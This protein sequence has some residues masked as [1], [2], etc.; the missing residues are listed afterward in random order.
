MGSD[1][2]ARAKT[3][4][5]HNERSDRCIYRGETLRR[6][7]KSCCGT[8]EIFECAEREHEVWNTKCRS[9]EF[10]DPGMPK[11]SLC[12]NT[13]N[14]GADLLQTILSFRAAY[15]GPFECIVIADGTTDDSIEILEQALPDIDTA[16]DCCPRCGNKDLA[17]CSKDDDEGP[18]YEAAKREGHGTAWTQVVLCEN[19]D[20]EASWN[21]RDSIKIIRNK[22]R[23]GCG[24][25]KAQAL[26]AA[27]GDV[28]MYSDGH[29]R[30]FK[31]AIDPL[32]ELALEE[33]C[34][35]CPGGAP[36]HC[37]AHEQPIFKVTDAQGKAITKERKRVYRAAVKNGDTRIGGT[38]L[39]YV[40][41]LN[42]SLPEKMKP[43]KI[44][45]GG[46]IRV[47]EHGLGI[48][49]AGKPHKDYGL[50]NATWWAVFLASKHTWENRLGGW[51]KFPGTWGSQEIGLALRCWFADVPV[52]ASRNDVV[53][54]RH[55]DWAGGPNYA[56]YTVRSSES[57]ANH[58]YCHTVVFDPK[59]V[60]EYWKPLWGR[61]CKSKGG[62][63]RCAES[64]MIEQAQEFREKYKRRTD[65]EFFEAFDIEYEP[66]GDMLPLSEI[67]A[68]ILAYKRPKAIQKCV[69]RLIE[70]GIENIWLWANEGAY[71]PEGVTRVFTDTEN[72]RTWPRYAIAS[73]A[74]TSHILFCDD[75]LMIKKAGLDGLRKA[76]FQYPDRNLGLIG[77]RFEKPFTSYNKRTFYK[78]HQIEQAEP[79]DML[80]PK[81]QLIP[82]DLAQRIYGQADLWQRMR[83]AVGST[84]GDDL[85]ATVAQ[86]IMGLP[87]ALVVP[88]EGKGYREMRDEAPKSAL[89]KQ[90]GRLKKKRGTVPMWKELGWRCVGEPGTITEAQAKE[91]I[92]DAA[93][94]A[95][96]DM[97]HPLEMVA[98]LSEL[99]KDPPSVFVEIGSAWGGSLYAYAQTCKPSAKIIAIDL[100]DRMQY[101]TQLK[102]IIRKLKAQGF[103]AEWIRGKSQSPEVASSILTSLSDKQIDFLH[104]D[105]SHAANDVLED[106]KIYGPLVRTGG[107]VAFHDIGG[108]TKGLN[109]AWPVIKRQVGETQEIVA[110]A[111]RKDQ[112][113]HMK[114]TGIGYFRKPELT[115]GGKQ[116]GQLTL[117]QHRGKRIGD[118]DCPTCGN[119]KTKL[120][121]FG[122]AKGVTGLSADGVTY[123]D[124][125]T[126]KKRETAE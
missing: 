24:K 84:S 16:F 25:A 115:T 91:R 37:W 72:A 113:G 56:P 93:E 81:G 119:R 57:R 54:H 66:A 62:E 88:S 105:G 67:T 26:E 77:A 111:W 51:N 55:R 68:I 31:G 83:N 76:A 79:V 15:S 11:L 78:S 48:G 3:V 102:R 103:D 52:Y 106:W 1:F 108:D 42:P 45:Y 17:R 75:D 125:R 124:C 109:K 118:V 74:E 41:K 123:R 32:V 39:K 53:G 89:C 27:T 59:T 100:G 65:A 47:K 29:C 110:P 58:F 82:R 28:V 96:R 2:L 36:L 50:R 30:W 46:K 21:W 60:D 114:R 121:V 61:E 98:I 126:C 64:D 10:F 8:V 63:K 116:E 80:W 40:E 14:E 99:A 97:Q 69:N 23:V 94:E 86:A 33:E 38:K 12:I 43:H 95:S 22:T 6:E 104:I 9:C 87:P 107:L 92:R 34:V 13:H 71:I 101:R 35:V 4:I 73:M 19:C 7:K 44:A 5:A 120:H 90:P 18:E 85:V 117:C 112:S 122:C 70:R 49:A 20:W